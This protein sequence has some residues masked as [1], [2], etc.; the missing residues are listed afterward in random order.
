MNNTR[1]AF[2]RHSRPQTPQSQHAHRLRERPQLRTLD[3][4]PQGP[5][6]PT[7]RLQPLGKSSRLAGNTKVTSKIMS[8]ML[9]SMSYGA[10]GRKHKTGMSVSSG[11]FSNFSGATQPTHPAQSVGMYPTPEES[12]SPSSLR[13]NFHSRPLTSP[14]IEQIAMGLHISRTPHLG[15]SKAYSTHAR[16]LETPPQ[17]VSRPTHC[18]RDSAPATVIHLPPPLQCSAIK[19]PRDTLES[20]SVCLL[21]TPLTPSDSY[22]SLS[23]LTSLEP[24][25]LSSAHDVCP[26]GCNPACRVSFSR[27]GRLLQCPL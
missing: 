4:D 18:R 1:I 16:Q 3:F 21:S 22:T 8:S 20:T 9:Q 6:S 25:Y 12:L 24:W 15:S 23:T 5:Q 11:L 7:L 27:C 13:E 19:K 10:G 2:G 17:A 26:P 14:T